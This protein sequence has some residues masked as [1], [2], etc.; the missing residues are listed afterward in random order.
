[1]D[2]ATVALA[3]KLVPFVIEVL[4]EMGKTDLRELEA[5]AD[6]TIIAARAAEKLIEKENP[7]EA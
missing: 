6:L 2:P 1:M 5:D 4:R 7:R 3:L